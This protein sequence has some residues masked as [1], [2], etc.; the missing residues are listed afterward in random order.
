MGSIPEEEISAPYGLS[1]YRAGVIK[2]LCQMG[3]TEAVGQS[4]F[5]VSTVTE[6]TQNKLM[7]H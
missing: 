1:S 5:G 6:L 2:H 3:N 4:G 7:M